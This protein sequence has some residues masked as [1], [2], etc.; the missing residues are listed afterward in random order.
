VLGQLLLGPKVPPRGT[1]GPLTRARRGPIVDP[2]TPARARE[3]RRTTMDSQLDQPTA[4][5]A[6][7]AEETGS[8]R[9]LVGID[10]SPGARAA[11]VQA[12]FTAARR[13][14][15]LDV[16]SVYPALPAWFGGPPPAQP[17]DEAVR[18]DTD[19]RARAF[20]DE[21]GKDPAVVD[22]VGAAAVPVRIRALPGTP[23]E[24]LVEASGDAD[25]LVVGSRGRGAVR[26]AV[27]GS[28]ALHCVT[29]ARCPVEVVHRVPAAAASGVVVGVDGSVDSRAALHAAIVEAARTGSPVRVVAAYEV[30][31][32][33]SDMYAVTAPTK[34][35]LAAE[36]ERIV[37]SEVA[38]VREEIP[39]E[40]AARVPAITTEAV[41][42]PPSDLLVAA[43]EDAELL[44]VASRGHGALR[45]LLLGSVAL[46]CVVHGRCPVLV[47]RTPRHTASEPAGESHPAT[48]YV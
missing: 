43:S 10:G 17:G 31:N 23:A 1:L 38:G 25:L 3:D 8:P 20:V 30:G 45:G 22:I 32:I 4:A 14:A 15:I 34:Q 5:P 13:S 39:A 19:T 6:T 9:V 27:L 26:S 12:W 35:R 42:G 2:S 29:H 18:V 33:W 21:V 44:V 40:V 41:E 24:A 37:D 16:V 47:V 48:V 36:L 46:R 11:L 28:V 7:G